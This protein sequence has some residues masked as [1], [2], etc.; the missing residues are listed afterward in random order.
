M[1][2]TSVT[3]LF[4][5]TKY[6]GLLATGITGFFYVFLPLSYSI[7]NHD[8]RKISC[9]ML[10]ST[11]KSTDGDDE[12]LHIEIAAYDKLGQEDSLDYIDS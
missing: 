7:T 12:I 8:L 1:D 11:S 6:L 10:V 5:I 9:L 4:S 3:H 2:Q